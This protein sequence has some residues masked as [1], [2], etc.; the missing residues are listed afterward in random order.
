M[1]PVLV[2]LD[3]QTPDGPW[4][5]R[6]TLRSSRIS[7]TVT[8]TLT[9]PEKRGSWGIPASLDSPLPL[10]LTMSGGLAGVGILTLAVV[11]IRRNRARTQFGE[12]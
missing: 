7:H 1:A 4:K 6:L 11:A 12:A 3:P 5:V 2:V 8:G 9:F 10:A